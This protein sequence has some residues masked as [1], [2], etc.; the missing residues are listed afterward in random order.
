MKGKTYIKLFN[1]LE[2]ITPENIIT[3]KDVKKN[4]SLY[5]KWYSLQRQRIYDL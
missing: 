2:V 3:K 1:G 4:E 5:C